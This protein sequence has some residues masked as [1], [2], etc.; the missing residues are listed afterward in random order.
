MLV[1]MLSF[2]PRESHM[3]L[4]VKNLAASKRKHEQMI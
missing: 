2:L 3:Y 1:N 4:L